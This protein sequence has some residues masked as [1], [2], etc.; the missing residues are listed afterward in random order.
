MLRGEKGE[1]SMLESL[2]NMST[3]EQILTVGTTIG[4]AVS[5]IAVLVGLIGSLLKLD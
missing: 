5:V 3:F 4:L 1:K 2:S